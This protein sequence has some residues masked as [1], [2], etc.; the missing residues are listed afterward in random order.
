MSVWGSL[1]SP[2]IKRDLGSKESEFERRKKLWS[3]VWKGIEE[4]DLS[5][6]RIG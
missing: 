4:S 5:F 3:L 1:P 2:R 6:L